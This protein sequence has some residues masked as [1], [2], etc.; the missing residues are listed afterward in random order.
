MSDGWNDRQSDEGTG[1]ATG[2]RNRAWLRPVLLLLLV[3]IAVALAITFRDRFSLEALAEQE[4]EL[5]AQLQADP[6][7]T[8][9][10]AFLIYAAVTGLAIPIATPL[11][12]AYAWLFGFWPALVVVSFASTTGAS[13]S[14]LLSRYFLTGLVRR[15]FADQLRKFQDALD[16]DGA[17]FLFSLRLVP[18]VPFFVVNLVMGLT[19]MRLRSFWWIS[20]LGMLPG[21]MTYL[22]A[23]SSVGSM[24]ELARRG[25]GGVLTPQLLVA[26]TLLGLFPLA[27]KW[28]VGR[29][30]R[31]R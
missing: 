27:A 26:F 29:L 14:F 30:R 5:R 24:R 12:L 16:A 8:F 19:R 6:L 17:Y 20:Q 15:R 7:L 25:V 10:G 21:T 18:Y 4:A 1:A 11:S 2:R 22:F 9:F 23:G 28:C 3:G 31:R 13:L